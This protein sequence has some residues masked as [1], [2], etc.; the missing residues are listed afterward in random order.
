M[1]CCKNDK[2]SHNFVE[3]DI[4]ETPNILKGTILTFGELVNP[5]KMVYQEPYLFLVDSRA[6]KR[7]H[8]INIPENKYIVNKG[9]P[10]KGPGEL[11]SLFSV[12]VFDNKLWGFDITL[13]KFTSYSL[14]SLS[15]PT[16]GYD[17]EIYFKG[18]AN[19]TY[20]PTW[21]DN[22]TIVSTTFSDSKNR[23]IFTD[24]EGAVI[25]ER[26]PMFPA[27]SDNIP[28]TIHNLSF[29]SVL[30]VKP[31][32]SKVIVVNRY[33]DLIEIYDLQNDTMK[34]IKTHGNFDPVYKIMNVDG[35][36]VMGQDDQMRFGYIDV[37]V[38]DTKI[39]TLYSGR[40][41]GEGKA[42]YADIVC[43]FDWDGNFITS[44]KIDNRAIA[45]ALK[46]DREFLTIEQDNQGKSLLKT[47]MINE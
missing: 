42:N 34:R 29:Q 40:I 44:Y 19:Q 27:P 14:D 18:K 24:S 35:N 9:T 17:E 36:A 30:K 4:Q 15:S 45:I 1:L 12:D 10:G 31:D 33:A 21:I 39:Y 6:Y 3:L 28:Q 41:R 43:V 37:T 32:N 25:K 20:G 2:K 23:L 22:N 26:F 11:L 46:N 5:T 8:V 7:F 13:S 38:S 16:Y 47:Y